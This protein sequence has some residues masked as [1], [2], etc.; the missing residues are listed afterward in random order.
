M[1]GIPVLHHLPELAQTHVHWVGGA[2]QPSHPVMPFCC[3]C[4]SFPA[5]GSFLMNRL[6]ASGGQN[7]ELQL[8]KQN[9]NLSGTLE[10]LL[11][12]RFLL[13][14]MEICFQG[15]LSIWKIHFI[16]YI[17]SALQDISHTIMLKY[18]LKE[19]HSKCSSWDSDYMVFWL[20]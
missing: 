10:S 14:T 8:L 2:I 5:S 1:P 12:Y 20:L 4:Q 16:E 9:L 7:I 3:R 19:H 18:S 6:Y 17:F 13:N 11:S 15:A